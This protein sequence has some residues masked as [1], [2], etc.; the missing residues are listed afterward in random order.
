MRRG[1][2]VPANQDSKSLTSRPQRALSKRATRLRPAA[3]APGA[4]CLSPGPE[5][6]LGSRAAEFH[7]H[8]CVGEC[9]P[10]SRVT[11]R[12]P[13]RICSRLSLG[14]RS[15][16]AP[17]RMRISNIALPPFR[18]PC[19]P[20]P[21]RPEKQKPHAVR[22]CETVGTPSPQKGHPNPPRPAAELYCDAI[23]NGSCNPRPRRDR[24]QPAPPSPD[25]AFRYLR[26]FRY[27]CIDRHE[28]PIDAG[29]GP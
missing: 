21:H 12:S 5:F 15:Y 26:A 17:S 20:R 9:H 6:H 16:I 3:N 19:L 28:A 7:L 14:R 2:N 18:K 29:G 13:R 11:L 1:I 23:D 24:R 10:R 22:R 25:S 27:I 4:V 8:S